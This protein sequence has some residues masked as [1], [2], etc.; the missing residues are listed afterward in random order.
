MLIFA[1]IFIAGFGQ[2]VL[3]LWN[4]LV[5]GIFGLRPLSFWEAVGLL[6]LSW[7]LFGGFRGAPFLGAGWGGR[8]RRDRWRNLSP[9]QRAQLRQNLEGRCGN[10]FEAP[11]VKS[12]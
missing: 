5:P 9:E 3:Q 4:H 10:R 7:L 8:R 11:A 6:S 1:A 2:A 12:E